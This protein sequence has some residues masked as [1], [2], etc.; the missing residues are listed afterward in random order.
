MKISFDIDGVLA[1]FTTAFWHVLKELGH[2]VPP[3]GTEPTDWGWTCWGVTP[4]LLTKGFQVISDTPNFWTKSYPYADNVS[5]LR[6]F[7][8][9]AKGQEIFFTTSRLVT[10]G[11]PV[12]LQTRTWLE[13]QLIWTSST[14][15][16]N[17]LTILVVEKTSSK[18]ELYKTLNIT[19]S[20]DDYGPTIMECESIPNHKAILLDRPWNQEYNP[21]YRAK[22]FKDFFNELN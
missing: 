9:E 3:L 20:I 1:N 16:W 4:A 22:L 18:V 2:P 15:Y 6:R 19:H 13:N 10:K 14:T 7:L 5:V 17:H 12:S 11:F 21:K 8:Y